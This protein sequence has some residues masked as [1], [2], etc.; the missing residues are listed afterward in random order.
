MLFG[1]EV[2]LGQGHIALNGELGLIAPHQN[3]LCSPLLPIFGPLCEMVPSSPT[4]KGHRAP[5][6]FRSMSLV[7]KR[8]DVCTEAGLGPGDIVL[9]GDPAP[10][11]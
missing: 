5:A 9:D 6:N 2:G 7:A 11:P 10:L 3:G 4:Q 1:T 8:L